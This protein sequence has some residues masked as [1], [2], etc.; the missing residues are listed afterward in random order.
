VSIRRFLVPAL[1]RSR[2]V[3][4][5]LLFGLLLIMGAGSAVRVIAQDAST[6]GHPLVGTWV[7]D[8]GEDN[9]AVASFTGD[10]TVTDIES[11][12]EVGLGTWVAT[13]PT[14]GTLTFV[15]FFSDPESGASG[16]I[17][18][19]GTLD[20]DEASDTATGSYTATGAGFDGT[21]Y[22]MDEGTV[23]ATRI[24]PEA[25]ELGGS[26]IPVLVVGTPVASP[27]AA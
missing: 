6:E 24:P 19:R 4:L 18:I 9:L 5:V 16:T 8:A 3:A 23:I 14:S 26:P 2:A 12:G 20:Y 17:V 7:I 11:S 27:A 25:P 1:G 15:I 22:F 13:S 21:V 10:G